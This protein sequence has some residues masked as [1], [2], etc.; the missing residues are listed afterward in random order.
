M[1]LNP[2]GFHGMTNKVTTYYR[3]KGRDLISLI[4]LKLD[5]YRNADGDRLS[6]KLGGLELPLLNGVDCFL[7]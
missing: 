1:R 6:M 3:L 2:E 5:I 7:R 4:K